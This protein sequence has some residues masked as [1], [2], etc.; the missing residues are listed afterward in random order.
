MGKGSNGNHDKD[1]P[2]IQPVEAGPKEKDGEDE[3]GAG[4]SEGGSAERSWRFRLVEPTGLVRSLRGGEQVHGEVIDNRLQIMM[5]GLLLGYCPRDIDL[6][7]RAAM[8][9]RSPFGKVVDVSGSSPTVE[10]VL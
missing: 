8:N 7:I 2:G 10:L 9:G 4:G 6:Q 5:D 3:A 1:D